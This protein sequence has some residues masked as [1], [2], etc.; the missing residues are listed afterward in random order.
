MIST[1]EKVMFLRAV[2]IFA[3]VD[4]DDLR[5]VA[6]E[7]RVEHFA[8]GE[9]VVANGTPA[10]C[11]FVVAA[12]R[13]SVGDDAFAEEL[14]PRQTFG[15]VEMFVLGR[16]NASV[17]AVKDAALLAIDR[18]RFLDLGRRR[19]EILVEVIRV[20]GERLLIVAGDIE[21]RG[22]VER[23]PGMSYIWDLPNAL[24]D[25]AS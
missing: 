8:A 25:A 14:G 22:Q 15:E 9:T 6:D 2:P 4:L 12:G 23:R 16:H 3:G 17:T 18:D 19:P 7:M 20:L 21:K 11:L 24:G 13:V 5:V 10:T 1:V